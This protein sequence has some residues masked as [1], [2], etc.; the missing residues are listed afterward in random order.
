MH[1]TSIHK[2]IIGGII[3]F[4]IILFFLWRLSFVFFPSSVY[5]YSYGDVGIGISG[6]GG[7]RA[8]LSESAAQ[9]AVATA[10]TPVAPAVGNAASGRVS[11]SQEQRLIIKTGSLSLAV[12]DVR[13]AI[14]TISAFAEAHQGFVVQSSV[15]KEGIIPSGYITIRIPSA[16]F[17]SGVSQIKE[18]GILQN[19]QVSGTDVTEEFVDL[20]AQLTNLKATESQFLS[21]MKQATTIEDIL[22][23]QRELSSVRGTIDQIEGRIKF[24]QQSAELSSLTVYLS[25]RQQ[26]LPVV[27]QDEDWQPIAVFK[28]AIRSLVGFAKGLANVV[29]WV[30]VYIPVVLGLGVLL[31]I[32]RAIWRKH[33]K[34]TRR[35]T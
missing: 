24:L 16:V 31:F 34:H 17:D 1:I 30:V 29:I 14:S 5:E 7:T 22:A 27:E 15:N 8:A 4:G 19:E 35:N 26:A 11:A 13:E 23:V 3:G 21:I 32:A 9:D 6:Y 18:I 12:D 33:L 10:P 28:D 20:Q 2:R 25:T